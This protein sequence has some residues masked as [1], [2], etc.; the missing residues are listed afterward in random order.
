MKKIYSLLEK[1]SFVFLILF[2]LKIFGGYF[3]GN[4]ISLK[5]TYQDFAEF[6]LGL[7]TLSFI[8][9]LISNASKII[10]AIIVFFYSKKKLGYPFS[11]AALTIVFGIDAIILLFIYLIYCEIRK[12][13][14]GD[15]EII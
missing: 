5:Y 12:A 15:S 11:W 8:D 14:S 7:Q 2:I 1:I 3:L 13:N 6:K 10:L 9:M 4:I